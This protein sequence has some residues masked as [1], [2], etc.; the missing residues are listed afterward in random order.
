MTTARIYKPAKTAMQSGQAR[1]KQWLLKFDRVEPREIEPLMGW[2][3]SG[4][5][6]QQVQLWFDSKEEL[7][8]ETLLLVARFNTLLAG[9]VALD[10]PTDLARRYRD[11]AWCSCA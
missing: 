5:T 6:R 8:Q 9:A 11:F 2:T 4:D 3:S 7:L 10:S 1:T